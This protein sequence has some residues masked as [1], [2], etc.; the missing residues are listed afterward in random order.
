MIFR[1]KNYQYNGKTTKM[2]ISIFL[3][4]KIGLFSNICD[5][6][7]RSATKQKETERNPV[8]KLSFRNGVLTGVPD[9]R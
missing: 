5:L 6:F 9:V 7:Y 4:L 8:K 3:K 1:K 2:N